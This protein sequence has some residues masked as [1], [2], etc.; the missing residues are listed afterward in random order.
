MLYGIFTITE[1]QCVT[2]T[3]SLLCRCIPLIDTKTFFFG[4]KCFKIRLKLNCVTFF[5][6]F[7][8]RDLTNELTKK[9][10]IFGD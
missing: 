4:I 2:G 3:H 1:A 7:L 9:D 8:T 5:L 6:E 10:P